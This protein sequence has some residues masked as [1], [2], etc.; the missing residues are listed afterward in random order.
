[1]VVVNQCPSIQIVET[2]SNIKL[3]WL[4]DIV[5]VILPQCLVFGHFVFIRYINDIVMYSLYITFV[6]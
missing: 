2:V 3:I 5:I 4:G 6:N 1:M